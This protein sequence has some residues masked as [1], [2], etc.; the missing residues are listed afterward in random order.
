MLHTK[1]KSGLLLNVVIGKGPAILKLLSS[2]N[3][4]LLIRRDS[5]LVLDDSR[6]I[7]LPVRVF[8]KIYMAITQIRAR[9]GIKGEVLDESSLRVFVRTR[10][11]GGTE[12]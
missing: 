1:V 3:E 5:L 4:V 10:E 9:N 7:V 8:M 12:Q 6:V 2:K 11:M